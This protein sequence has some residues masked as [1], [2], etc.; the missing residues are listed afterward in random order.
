MATP[1]RRE[2]YFDA[3][4]EILSTDDHGG[5]KQAPL[6]RHLSVTTGSFYNYFESW[7]QFKTEF[8]QHWL[9]RRTLQLVDAA[10]LVRQSDQRLELL[11]EF[12]CG[13]PHRAESAIRAWAHSDTEVRTVQKVVDDQR[14]E[15]VREA[16]TGLLGTDSDAEN[17]ARM[18]L[19]ILYGYQQ[20]LPQP[21]LEHLRW[22][23]NRTFTDALAARTAV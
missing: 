8:L 15:V 10:R 11:I 12:A 18:G 6:C 13:L 3:A 9:H 19:F 7:G 1:V 21:A 23:L 17:F 22:A 5:L 20:T 16:V 14:F 4:I 2:D